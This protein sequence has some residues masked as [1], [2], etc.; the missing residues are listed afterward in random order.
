VYSHVAT[1]TVIAA[2]PASAAASG[3]APMHFAVIVGSAA[4]SMAGCVALLRIAH[5]G[6]RSR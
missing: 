3:F 6:A 2:L 1:G 5:S 4:V